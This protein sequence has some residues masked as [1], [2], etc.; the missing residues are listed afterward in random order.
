[1]TR[2]NLAALAIIAGIAALLAFPFREAV[3]HL[4]VVPLAYVFWLI[5]LYYRSISQAYWWIGIVLV[6]LIVLG[7]SLLPEIKSKRSTIDLQREERGGVESLANALAK[8]RKGTYFKWVIANR[9]GRLA[10][11]L[12]SL[13]EHG[14][15][16]SAY[17]PLTAEGWEAPDEVQQY[18]ERG[19][20]GSFADHSAPRWNDFSQPQ[21]TSL[22]LD[23]REAVEF[24]ETKFQ[25][26]S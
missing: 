8:S 2:R 15:P 16:R 1:M 7:Y 21:R 14:K 25:G 10:Q 20:H 24:L 4:L 9:L 3:H 17:A 12:L 18:L 6:A 13:R 26:D 19:L 5:G 22:D 11:Q 23:A